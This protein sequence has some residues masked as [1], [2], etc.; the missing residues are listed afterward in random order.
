VNKVKTGVIGVGHL[1]RFH[2]L[3]YAQIP[4]ADLVGV[5]DSDRK[6]AEH[7]AGEAQTRAFDSIDSL[8]EEVDGVSIAVPTDHHHAV[9]SKVLTKGI[10]C[11]V[12]KPIAQNI[13][14]AD[15]L[16][17]LAAANNTIIQV[18][19]IER[20]NPAFRALAGFSLAPLFIESHRLAPFNPRGTE[21]SV[22]LDLM[23]HDIDIV[24]HLVNHP[25]KSIDASGV[26]VVSDTIDIANARIHFENGTVANLTASRISQK[27]MR[28]M[29]MFQKD[30]YVT[31]DFLQKI[32]E[33]YKLDEPAKESDM[34]L[35]EIGVGDNK[36]TVV[37]H[38][39]EIPQGDGLFTE[40]QT[41]INAIRG[42]D[43]KGVPGEAARSALDIAI[44]ILKQMEN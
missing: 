16:I 6:R 5:Y 9:A 12:E 33:V 25:V 39:P 13:A 2:A 42:K 35:G 40:L 22:V 31:V 37:Y 15:S 11:L 7:V 27:K 24:L 28:K 41:F 17:Q 19:H 1:G 43:K 26:A 14:E 38:R 3:N 18:G 29:R 4:D 44:N 21:V 20:F 32:S 30:T 36:K 10:P 8:L 34:V 23:I